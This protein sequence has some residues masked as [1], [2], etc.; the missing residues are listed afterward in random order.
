[1]LP[2]L[3]GVLP[4]AAALAL[5]WAAGAL[6][7]TRRRS[8]LSRPGG[9]ACGQ[10]SREFFFFFNDTATP[11]IYALPLP[12]ALPIYWDAW[13]GPAPKVPFNLARLTYRSFMDYTDRKSTRL[14]SS[15]LVISYAVFCLK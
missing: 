9:Q 3:S 6:L 8:R 2:D 1:M 7:G 13:L 11:E 10:R 4:G 14:H 12:D 15:H 5:V